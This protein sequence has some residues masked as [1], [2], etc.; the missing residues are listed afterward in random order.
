MGFIKAFAGSI[1]G[2]F[3]DQWEDFYAP[4]AGVPTTAGVYSAVEEKRYRN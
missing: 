2:T 1:G 4:K 3:A